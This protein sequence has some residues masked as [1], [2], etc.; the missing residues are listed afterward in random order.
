MGRSVM[1]G[2]YCIS[3]QNYRANKGYQG[4]WVSGG[5]NKFGLLFGAFNAMVL[6]SKIIG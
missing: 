5:V 6:I 2:S 4:Q 1:T 3:G